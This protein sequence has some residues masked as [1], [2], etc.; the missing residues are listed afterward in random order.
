MGCREARRRGRASP[1]PA[2]ERARPTDH[3]GERQ[4][5][6]HVPAGTDRPGADSRGV[7]GQQDGRTRA[8][9]DS[10]GDAGLRDG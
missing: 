8:G 6:D 5:P 2:A 4:D 1:H 9:G 3:A 10:P 7:R